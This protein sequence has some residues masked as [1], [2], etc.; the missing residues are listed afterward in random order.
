M[1]FYVVHLLILIEKYNNE[2]YV[3]KS[4]DYLIHVVV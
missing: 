3:L 2:K 4:C 1:L